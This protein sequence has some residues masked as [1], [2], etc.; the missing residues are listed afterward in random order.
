M[1]HAILMFS[2]WV[3]MWWCNSGHVFVQLLLNTN[4]HW[5]KNNFKSKLAPSEVL[6]APCVDTKDTWFA[7]GLFSK[8]H[9]R[10]SDRRR[11]PHPAVC[12]CELALPSVYLSPNLC[13]CLLHAAWSRSSSCSPSSSSSSWGWPSQVRAAG[14]CRIRWYLIIASTGPEGDSW[15]CLANVMFVFAK[16]QLML[17]DNTAHK[18]LNTI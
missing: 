4:M 2:C 12:V 7:S 15:V 18:L 6:K 10:C 8:L 16:Q 17:N 5:L 11:R 9:P 1:W 14:P 13:V 3:P